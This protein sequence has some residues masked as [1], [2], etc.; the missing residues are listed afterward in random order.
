MLGGPESPRGIH[1]FFP[2]ASI[3]EKAGDFPL[4]PNLY[5]DE[6]FVAA[7]GRRLLLP[8][9]R[10]PSLLE[11]RVLVH[12]PVLHIRV[13]RINRFVTVRRCDVKNRVVLKGSERKVV[14]CESLGE[15]SLGKFLGK[16]RS[17]RGF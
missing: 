7:L 11:S 8:L 5:A 3:R 1:S 16:V 17:V 12:Y 13:D 10:K 4:T 9:G 6:L 14:V 15:Q 2:E